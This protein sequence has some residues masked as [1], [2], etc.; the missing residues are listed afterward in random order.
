MQQKTKAFWINLSV[1][2]FLAL[3]SVGMYR[4]HVSPYY[5]VAATLPGE[6]EGAKREG[7]SL[8][9]DDLKRIT[10]VPDSQ[11]AAYLYSQI[12]AGNVSD[13]EETARWA[14]VKGTATDA[15][16]QKTQRL[17]E[18][19]APQLLLAEQAALLPDCDFHLNWKLGPN[20][21]LPKY[22]PAREAARLLAAKA[23][24]QSD[25]GHPEAALHTI[26]IG[27]RMAQHLS[28]EPSLIPLLVRIAIE[29]IMD[30]PFQYVLKHYA[31]RPDVL[32]LA[33]QTERGFGAMPDIAH[34]MRGEVVCT[35][36]WANRIRNNEERELSNRLLMTGTPQSVVVDA[37]E[38]HSLAFW[39]Q[40]FAAL[41]ST[42]ED[43]MA[44]YRAFKAINVATEAKATDRN[45]KQKPTYELSVILCP[46]FSTAADKV[47]LNEAERRLRRTFLALLAY[48]QQK[49]R[50]PE[51]LS[52]LSPS[53][54]ND[55]FISQPLHYRKTE[56]GF[57]LYSVGEN[58]TDDGG[59]PIPAHKGEQ[60]PD[61]VLSFP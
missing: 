7:L 24:M 1:T 27:M 40:V 13:I 37:N 35:R 46:Y 26:W 51:T 20:L 43:P 47:V 22:A 39:R 34:A 19:T 50:F 38:A 14:V 17:L 6:I 61:I 2:L 53:A 41:K 42:P 54:P 60:R 31:N 15:E 3:V 5:T 44:T 25:A 49:G 45:D 8:T 9:P 55:P 57:L 4:H 52:L 59:N 56:Q 36:I 58:L 16:R 11:N 10:P 30:R 33:E 32:R 48:R 28:R 18:K 21:V 23:V 29:S 12:P